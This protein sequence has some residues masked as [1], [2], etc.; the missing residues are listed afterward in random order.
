M[1]TFF[2][3]FFQSKVGLAI[4]LVF[5]G[6]IGFAFASMDVSNTGM[7]GGVAG[8]DRVAIV[9]DRTIS[10]SDLQQNAQN[11][12]QSSRENNPTLS[13]EGF[14]A[15]GGFDD[16]LDQML[17]RAAIAEFAE[18]MGLR[19]GDRLVTSEITSVPNFQGLDGKFDRDV[20]LSSLRQRGLTED[21]V[22]EDLGTSLLARQLILPIAY[23][24]S[25]PDSFARTY[26]ELLS[27]TR[28]GMAAM[29]PAEA[30]APEGPATNA[31]LQ[32]YYDENRARYIR[33]ERRVIRYATFTGEDLDNLPPV[34]NAQIAA[35]YEADRA[36]YQERQQ[37]S[38]TQLVVPTRAAA[39]AVIDEVDGGVTLEQSARSKSLE[40]TQVENVE[41]AA[42]AGSASQAVAQAAFSAAS[43]D[44]AGPVQ[45]SLGWYV[46]RV[47]EVT[48]ILPRTLAQVSDEI[49]T[50]LETERREQALQDLTEEL[51]QAFARGRSLEEAA[52]DIGIE[53]QTSRPLLADGRVYQ[54]PS[55]TAPPELAR[56]LSFAFEMQER[57]AQLSE[58]VNGE[59]FVIFDVG[60]ITRSATAPLA[61]IRQTVERQWRRDRGMVAAGQAAARVLERVQ[62]GASFAQAMARESATLPP[63]QELRISR[64]ELEDVGE[65]TRATI[66]F[67]SMAEGT[68]K[69]V[70]VQEQDRWFVV[71]LDDI[72][73]QDLAD[74]DPLIAGTA[75][76]LAQNAGDEWVQQFM[77]A[78]EASLTIERNEDGISAVRQALLGNNN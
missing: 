54:R 5:L 44:L 67:F 75:Q 31:Q 30:F 10:T 15:Q 11:A 39:Q 12:L 21:L 58:I 72:Q 6:L 37:R 71:Q 2:R 45:G 25:L 36:L 32:E 29:F 59:Q 52:D 64:R 28:T 74:D 73:T 34:T 61:E 20:F 55:E 40:T 43:G 56:V 46:V 62:G 53:V 35:R 66:L 33:P 27:E 57:S 4:T 38:F 78:A 51:E 77:R 65:V 26:A 60:R 22:R 14:V 24:A 69:R 7:F 3:K 76:Q 17:R 9:G 19:A 23:E 42:Y 70:A 13:M 1:I 48:R 63:A 47:D 41:R 49:R 50:T 16:I 8:G 18:S 68:T